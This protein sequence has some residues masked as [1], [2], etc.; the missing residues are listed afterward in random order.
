MGKREH[1]LRFEVGGEVHEGTLAQVQAEL[2]ARLRCT[3]LGRVAF[4][5]QHLGGGEGARRLGGDVL[6]RGGTD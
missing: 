6:H 1:S 3:S 5:G 4:F 2:D